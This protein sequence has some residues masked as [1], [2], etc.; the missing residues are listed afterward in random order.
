MTDP[1][2]PAWLLSFY[3]AWPDVFICTVHL[4]DIVSFPLCCRFIAGCA[5]RG[6]LVMLD[7][8]RL[9]GAGSITELWYDS[10]Y[11]EDKVIQAWKIMAK[12]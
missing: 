6:L 10:R 4:V 12:R 1:I 7:M 5:S 8:H 3:P 9:E 2:L 11:T